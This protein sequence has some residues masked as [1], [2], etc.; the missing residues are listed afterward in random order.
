MTYSVSW[1]VSALN[2]L[3]AVAA[4]R[5]DSR[6]VDEAAKWVDYTLRRHPYDVGESR[7][8]LDIQVWY[9]DVIG[10]LYLV[11][12]DATTVRVMAVAP[13]RRPLA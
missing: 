9:G 3:T 12:S 5:G 6:S 7:Q 8:S 13:A 1:V 10:V 11:D 4:A 2:D